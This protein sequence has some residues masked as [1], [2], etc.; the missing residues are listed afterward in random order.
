MNY[1]IVSLEPSFNKTKAYLFVYTNR[2]INSIFLFWVISINSDFETHDRQMRRLRIGTG[3]RLSSLHTK[4]WFK[5]HILSISTS[6]TPSWNF[7]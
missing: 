5:L 1:Y 4:M 3:A 2:R 6:S 7:I